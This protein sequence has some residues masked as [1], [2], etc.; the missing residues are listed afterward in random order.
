MALPQPT[1]IQKAASRYRPANKTP[2]AQTAKPKP[3]IA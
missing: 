3:I 1:I 2:L